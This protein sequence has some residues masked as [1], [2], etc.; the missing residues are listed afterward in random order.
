MDQCNEAGVLIQQINLKEV[1][2]EEI[3][4][5]HQR[6]A[7]SFLWPCHETSKILEYNL[8]ARN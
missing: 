8:S 2:A 3:C 1:S 7:I 5:E 4:Q 6:K